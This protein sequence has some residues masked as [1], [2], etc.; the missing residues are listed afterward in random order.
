MGPVLDHYH[1]KGGR[2]KETSEK[3]TRLRSYC[4]I[5]SINIASNPD[6]AERD[7]YEGRSS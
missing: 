2:G 6:V 7:D 5:R 4:K 1:V 3:V